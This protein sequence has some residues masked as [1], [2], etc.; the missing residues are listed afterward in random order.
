MFID[1]LPEVLRPWRT[2][3]LRSKRAVKSGRALA[4]VSAAVET[5]EQLTLLAATPI[6]PLPPTNAG[7]IAFDQAVYSIGETVTIGLQDLNLAGTG[8]LDVQVF[9]S[10]GDFETVHLTEEGSTGLFTGVI[11]TKNSEAQGFVV[12]DGLLEIPRA[13][14]ISISYSDADDGTGSSK[15]VSDSANLFVFSDVQRFDFSNTNGT[16]SNEGFTTI[17]QANQWHVSNGRGVELGHSSS[18]SFYFGQGETL[19]GGGTYIANANG[20]LFSP[21]IDLGSYTGP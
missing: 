19:G 3:N 1:W 14:A 16:P 12:N 21:E 17:G 13:S 18:Y 2:R 11:V 8:S 7:Q 9:S 5:L 15:I 20:T 10:A 4:P 6:F